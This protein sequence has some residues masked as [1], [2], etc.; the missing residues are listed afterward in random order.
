MRRS[1]QYSQT[2]RLAR[3][4][5]SSTGRSLIYS[6]NSNQ[7]TKNPQP[8]TFLISNLKESRISSLLN[9]KQHENSYQ[10]P[11]RAKLKFSDYTYLKFQGGREKIRQ[12]PKFGFRLYFFLYVLTM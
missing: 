2:L 3:T 8:R 12:M 7:Q 9:L 4:E 6:L 5:K 11:F 10:S 1:I